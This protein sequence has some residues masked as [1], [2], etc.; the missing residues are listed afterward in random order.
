MVAGGTAVGL[1]LGI[2]L[3]AGWMGRRGRNDYSGTVETRE[4]Q[5]G[6][7]VQL[8]TLESRPVAPRSW[9]GAR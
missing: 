2:W 1:A 4:I 7:K 9:S 6:S 8:G 3:V 5:I